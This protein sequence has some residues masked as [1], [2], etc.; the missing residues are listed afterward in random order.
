MRRRLGEP[1]AES[2][3]T[4]EKDERVLIQIFSEQPPWFQVCYGH[5]SQKV[6]QTIT[7]VTELA[8]N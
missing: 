6:I 7:D 4:N 5:G 8:T 1:M 2:E 3:R